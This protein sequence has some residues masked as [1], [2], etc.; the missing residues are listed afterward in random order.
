MLPTETPSMHHPRRRNMAT[1]V[2]GLK[3]K[4]SHAKISLKMM[5]PRDI[6]GNAEEDTVDQNCELTQSHNTD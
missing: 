3:K 4:N 1:S 6:A 5:N 2:V